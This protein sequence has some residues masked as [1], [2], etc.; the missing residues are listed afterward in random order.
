MKQFLF[1]LMTIMIFGVC[2]AQPFGERGLKAGK[3]R[4]QRGEFKHMIMRRLNLNDEQKDKVSQLHSDLQRKQID[5]RAKISELRVDVRELFRAQQPDQAKIDDAI[6]KIAKLQ[7]DMKHAR[8]AFWFDVNKNLTPEQQKI[9]HR[10]GIRF[11]ADREQM[12]RGA[13]Q[14]FRHR[15]MSHD[16][17]FPR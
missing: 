2:Y 3:E 9:W 15:R 13:M 14:S 1:F 8:L 4:D 11:I 16:E 5:L 7:T 10:M 17:V 6:E 12:R